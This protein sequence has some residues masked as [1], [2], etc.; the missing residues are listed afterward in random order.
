V[1]RG[2][3][4]IRVAIARSFSG[5]SRVTLRYWF[6]WRG[7]SRK[8]GTGVPHSKLNA[9]GRDFVGL[10]EELLLRESYLVP[11]GVEAP[12]GAGW[13]LLGLWPGV[14]LARA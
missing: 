6:G 1:Q 3:A 10:R 9:V 11:E 8:G 7:F 4:L 14:A 13:S 12:V 2:C 5:S